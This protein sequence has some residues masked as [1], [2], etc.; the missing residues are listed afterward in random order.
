MGGIQQLVAVLP[1]NLDRPSRKG[2]VF[3][4][5][6]ITG[7]MI[8]KHVITVAEY[9]ISVLAAS[10]IAARPPGRGHRQVAPRDLCA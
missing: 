7:A 9:A 2:P 3:D 1:P 10:A 5:T 6:A 8:P 4:N